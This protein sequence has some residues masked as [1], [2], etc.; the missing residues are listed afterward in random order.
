MPTRVLCIW[1]P[2]WPIQRVIAAEPE[3]LHRALV[4]E[5]RDA[6]RGL[7]VAAANLAA[8]NAGAVIGMRMSELAALRPA[9]GSHAASNESHAA[10][11]HTSSR[12]DGNVHSA[13][14]S[15]PSQTHL[16]WEIRPYQPECDIDEL[17]ELSEQAQQFSP[18]VG[19]EPVEDYVWCGRTSGQPQGLLMDVTGIPPLF[20]GETSFLNAIAEWLQSRRYFAYMTIA[21]TVGAAWAFANYELRRKERTGATSTSSLE[22]DVSDDSTTSSTTDSLWPTC[23]TLIT[24]P[25]EEAE[26][27]SALPVAALRIDQETLVKLQRLGVGNLNQ[28][29]QLPRDGLA[30][31][32]GPRLMQRSDQALGHL[33]EP[34]VALHNSPDWQV[35]QDLEI[36]TRSLDTLNEVLRLLCKELSVRLKKQGRGALRCVCRMD[37]VARPP[38]VMQLGLFRPSDG[39]AHLHSLLCGQLEQTLLRSQEEAGEASRKARSDTKL[40]LHQSRAADESGCVWRVSLQATLTAPIVWEQ[41]QLFDDASVRH[42]QQLAGLIDTLS[43][44]LGRHAVVEATINRDAEPENAVRYQPLTGRRRD[45]TEQST[46]RKLNSRLANHGAEP[47]PTDP[48]RRPTRLLSPAEILLGAIAN[49]DGLPVSFVYENRRHQIAHH[50]GPERLESGWWRGPSMRRDYYR[51]ETTTGEWWWIYRDLVT[52]QWYLHGLF[53]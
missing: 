38:L 43:N 29:W 26:L 45:G 10:N 37:Q 22:A 21:S 1:L 47:R 18:L 34:I 53:S 6:R 17:C 31:R 11:R 24:E 52:E 13:Q 49:E 9:P 19:I 50:C 51:V 42:R 2:N 4:L 32:L 5:S 25:W 35:M 33:Y 36:A 44:R 12:V 46:L 14:S 28:L 8:R 39:D 27:L 40:P 16:V 48:M 20:G 3:L 7:V 15:M 30:S 41:T 23:R